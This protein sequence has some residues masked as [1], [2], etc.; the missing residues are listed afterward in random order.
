MRERE[1]TDAVGEIADEDAAFRLGLARALLRTAA[2]QGTGAG[3]R[4]GELLCHIPRK[5]IKFQSQQSSAN[6][7]GVLMT[8]RE[9]FG[10]PR[11]LW[12][13]IDWVWESE[14][15]LFAVEVKVNGKTVF[16]PDQLGNYTK[17][18][19]K[20]GKPYYGVLAL[21]TKTPPRDAVRRV[22]RRQGFVGAVVWDQS[23][24]LLRQLTPTNPD[25]AR[26]WHK[27]LAAVAPDI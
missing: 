5:E 6:E 25:H 26:R 17:A 2:S 10:K 16:Q 15:F 4:A 11:Q 24:P 9:M 27:L 21:T 3:A 8:M 13:F 20:T 23:A 12:N 19:K 18:A 7:L 14:E 22:A 1:L